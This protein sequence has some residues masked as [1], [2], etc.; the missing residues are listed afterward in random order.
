MCQ[1]LFHGSVH[2]LIVFS[3]LAFLSSP[4]LAQQTPPDKTKQ[5]FLEY[6]KDF[7]FLPGRNSGSGQISNDLLQILAEGNQKLRVYINYSFSASVSVEKRMT[8][9]SVFLNI[10]VNNPAISGTHQYRDFDL[11]SWLMPGSL[12]LHIDVTDNNGDLIKK[13]IVEDINWKDASA[14]ITYSFALE[15]VSRNG[16]VEWLINQAEFYYPVQYAEKVALLHESLSWYY[17]APEKIGNIRRMISPLD[18]ENPETLIL[19]EFTLCEAE[20]LL[21]E[22]RSSSLR[23]VPDEA[24]KDPLSIQNELDNIAFVLIQLRQK[25]NYSLSRIDSLFYHQGIGFVYEEKQDSAKLFFEKALTYNS[26]HIPARAAL[27]RYDIKD[28]NAEMAL[29]R[30]EYFSQDFGVPSIW[31][32]SAQVVLSEI[33][34]HQTEKS[35]KLMEDGRFLDATNLLIRFN[36]FCSES[37][38]WSCP[39]SL[40]DFLSMAHYG[41]YRSYLSVAERALQSENYSF[42][43]EYAENAMNYA[44]K[45]DRYINDVSGLYDLLQKVVNGYLENVEFFSERKDFASALKSIDDA[46]ALCEKYPSLICDVGLSEKKEL[47][48]QNLSSPQ[49]ILMQF[50]I[51]RLANVRG[52]DEENVEKIREKIRDDLSEGH[53]KAWGGAIEPARKILSDVI[54]NTLYYGLNND[55]LIYQR[56]LSLTQLIQDEECDLNRQKIE[57]M[58]AGLKN[59]LKNGDYL[60]AKDIYDELMTINNQSIH[61][62]WEMDS[63]IRA[64]SHVNILADYQKMMHQAQRSYFRGAREGFD[65]FFQNYEKAT[66]FYHHNLLAE[67]DVSHE[68]LFDFAISSSNSSLVKQLVFYYSENNAHENAFQMLKVLKEMRLDARELKD[69]QQKSGALAAQHVMQQNPSSDPKSYIAK[70]TNGDDWFRFY[71][72]SFLKN[73]P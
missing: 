7:S 63:E 61:C 55:S 2:L 47:L 44:G 51:S 35:M 1:K 42:S 8:A 10:K 40:Y 36:D 9:D 34:D 73:L 22:M 68:S 28:D 5:T 24:G 37:F 20:H 70:L 64:L 19:Q 48:A 46:I 6:E 27:V 33:Y 32:D 13:E 59:Q 18:A 14:P 65:L 12:R 11:S 41:M 23:F 69:L 54:E 67:Y 38:I 43:V 3:F 66:Q 16:T 58:L 49:N 30:M 31:K 26:M 60:T 45:H 62:K 39:S 15:K 25:F 57:T 50:D 53:L 17:A 71:E 21:A 56:V 4:V 72:R 52:S 29:K